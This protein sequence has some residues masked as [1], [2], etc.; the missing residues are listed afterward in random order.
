MRE[1]EIDEIVRHLPKE[2]TQFFYFKDRYAL[3][4]LADLVGSGRKVREIR[5]SSFGKLLDRPAVK[6]V[7]ETRGDG[8]LRQA[9]LEAAWPLD[10]EC[11]ILTIGK[12]GTDDKKEWDRVITRLPA[13]GTI[14]S[15]SS[16]FQVSTISAIANSFALTEMILFLTPFIPTRERDLRPWPG[17]VLILI[18]NAAKR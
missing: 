13:P 17:R 9:D 12:W 4:L 14:W 1:E 16:I 18:L 10:P 2:R 11:Y 6:S 5:N 7:L 3:M 8:I 15:C